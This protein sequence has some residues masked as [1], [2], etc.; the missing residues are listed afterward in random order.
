MESSERMP[1][2]RVSGRSPVSAG[3]PA[4]RPPRARRA[5]LAMARAPHDQDGVVALHRP[6]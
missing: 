1:A 2:R 3:P 4:A 5:A 6:L